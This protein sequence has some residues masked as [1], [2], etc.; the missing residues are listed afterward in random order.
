MHV[1]PGSRVG[2]RRGLTAI[3]EKQTLKG[4]ARIQSRAL[5]TGSFTAD[6]GLGPLQ[7]ITNNGAFTI[8]APSFDGSF[9]LLITNGASASTVTFS[10]FT[11]GTSTGDSLTTTNTNKFLVSIAR[12]NGVST[13]VIKALQ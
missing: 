5:V 12:V 1:N 3:G 4:G 2:R 7:Y 10:G 11:V 8:T 9:M 13:Y 6:P